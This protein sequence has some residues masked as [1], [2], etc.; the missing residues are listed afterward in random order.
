MP[1]ASIEQATI[2]SPGILGT[3]SA[4]PISLKI[5]RSGHATKIIG[6]WIYAI[7]GSTVIERAPITPTGPGAF[8][9]VAV[10]LGAAR[11]RAAIE[12]TGR[13]LFVIGGDAPS[14][15]PTIEHA[16]IDGDGDLAPFFMTVTT[17]A[18]PRTGAMS[19]V[20]GNSLYILGGSDGAQDLATVERAQIATDGSLM[21]FSSQAPLS[22][23]RL[24]G[25]LL[26][27]KLYVIG[28]SDSNSLSSIEVA[29]ISGSDLGAFQLAP[30]A[31]QAERTSAAAAL[32]G[33]K[34][35]VFGGDG[36]SG[37][38][39]SVEVATI[40]SDNTLGPFAT[41][42]GLTSPGNGAVQVDNGVIVGP[43]SRLAPIT[44]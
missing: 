27:D 9:P 10:A 8:E 34:L 4:Y 44:P 18:A 19:I 30:I 20:L 25:A 35:Y 39:S 15:L 37:P 3:F 13:R 23:L 43:P 36:L 24:S 21:A 33:N 5:A 29:D 32:L 7:G 22:S 2:Q 11:T 28:G 17:L 1:V 41:V 12:V 38:V 14:P 16:E 6:R 42:A 26:G 31:L 40:A